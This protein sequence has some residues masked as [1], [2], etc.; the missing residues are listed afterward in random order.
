[1]MVG[2]GMSYLFHYSSRRIMSEGSRRIMSDGSRCIIWDSPRITWGEVLWDY[3]PVLSVVGGLSV[4]VFYTSPE[5][6]NP[7][8]DLRSM[9]AGSAIYTLYTLYNSNGDI[10]ATNAIIVGIATIVITAVSAYVRS[11]SE[12]INLA[13]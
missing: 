8:T 7:E 6:C 12:E 11:D 9:L 2:M 1:M 13:K 5:I 10:E 3:S 4:M